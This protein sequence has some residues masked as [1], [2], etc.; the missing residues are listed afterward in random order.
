MLYFLGFLLY[1]DCHVMHRFVYANIRKKGRKES[2]E[3]LFAA[4]VM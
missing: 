1:I 4:L 2:R 3:T